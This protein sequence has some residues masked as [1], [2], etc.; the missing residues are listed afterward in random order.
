M[1]WRLDGECMPALVIR[2]PRRL[3]LAATTLN[4]EL[5]L[6]ILFLYV[7]E[8]IFQYRAGLNRGIPSK[9]RGPGA[10]VNNSSI[11]GV[12]CSS[13]SDI[14]AKSHTKCTTARLVL[15]SRRRL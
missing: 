7:L 4:T 13:C 1:P 8:E 11:W 2:A 14:D 3:R 15:Y 10:L 9:C 5:V 12:P 6:K